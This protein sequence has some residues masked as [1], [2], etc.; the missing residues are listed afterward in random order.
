MSLTLKGSTLTKYKRTRVFIECGT[1][2]GD[3]VQLAKDCGFD[4]IYTI[5][6]SERLYK[7]SVARQYHPDRNG[8]TFILG[9]TTEKLPELLATLN[10]PCTF[11]LD[12]HFPQDGATHVS[13]WSSC[14]TL[15]ELKAIER[16][17]IKTHTIL[18]DD[19]PDFKSG[20]HDHITVDQL[21]AAIKRINPDYQ[22]TFEDG[23][24]P[25]SIL[26]ATLP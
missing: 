17:G 1:Y 21:V 22:I 9:D 3:G 15:L 26:V 18:I 24:Q 4:A 14:P 10:E 16:H 12:A 8:I 6:I 23:N 20:I 11:W 5:E 25:G 19:I 13:S 7:H 2:A